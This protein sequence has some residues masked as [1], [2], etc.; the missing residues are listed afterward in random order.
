MKN[1]LLLLVIVF[2]SS[3]SSRIYK[4]YQLGVGQTWIYT[5]NGDDPFKDESVY[6]QRVIAISSDYVQYIQNDRDTLSC[7]KSWFVV[8]DMTL[9]KNKD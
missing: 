2:L 9:Q 3:C 7:S 6:N 8:G 5:M 4:Q 1:L